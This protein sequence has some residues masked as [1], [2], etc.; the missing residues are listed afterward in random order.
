LR[1]EGDRISEEFCKSSARWALSMCAGV[2]KGRNSVVS[3]K[4]NTRIIRDSE[5]LCQV[6]IEQAQEGAQENRTTE[7][8]VGE[9]TPPGGR[10][11]RK[12]PSEDLH[13]VVEYPEDS[14]RRLLEQRTR[15]VFLFSICGE[16]KTETP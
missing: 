12:N 1:V 16:G 11:G 3:S 13:W 14:A 7:R 5:E 15:K 4:R 6:G 10:R 2:H 8:S 9:D